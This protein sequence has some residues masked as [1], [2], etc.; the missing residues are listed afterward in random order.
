MLHYVKEDAMPTI[1]IDDDVYE[2]LQKMARP[3]EDTPNSVLRRV[4]GLDSSPVK[5]EKM[6]TTR[7]AQVTQGH[8]E[9]TPQSAFR[10]PI[11]AV[12][13]RLGGKG[14][15][16]K[17]LNEVEKLMADRLSVFDKTDIPSGSVRWQKSAEW[18]VRVMRE[19]GLLKL[20]SETPRGLW[21]LTSKGSAEADT[22]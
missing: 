21:V 4:A 11:L 9:K 12:L 20:V 15:R 16:M 7:H 3:F 17:V 1:R 8:G 10:Q 19:Q 6:A 5:E 2:W 14:D 22:A 13:R 18:E